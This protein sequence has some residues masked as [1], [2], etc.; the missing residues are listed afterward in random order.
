[1]VFVG[2]MDYWAN[3]DAV[4]WFAHEVF[5][6]LLQNNPNRRFYIVGARPT[7]AVQTLA[8]LAGVEVTGTV[9]DVRPY[10]AH[11]SLSVAP[12][13]IARGI[14]NKVLEAMAM[15][16]AVVAS[17]AACEG[18]ESDSGTDL[19]VADSVAEWITTIDQLEGA[20]DEIKRLGRNAREKILSTYTWEQ[21]L[22]RL[23]ALLEPGRDQTKS[24]G[25][26]DRRG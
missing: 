4:S 25:R 3:V 19:M 8:K 6:Q 23:D 16:R 15:G 14:Q 13:R 26:I 11:A 5:P 9:P 24:P 18:I 22:Q 12:L 20:E 21:N 10:V 7:D 2:A 17:P 1:M